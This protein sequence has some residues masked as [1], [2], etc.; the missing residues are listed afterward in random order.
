MNSPWQ[1]YLAK[2]EE[3][4]EDLILLLQELVHR[5][6][7]V[8]EKE[9][10]LFIMA[11]LEKRGI[12]SDL[13]NLDVDRL[14]THPAWVETGLSYKDRPNL[15]ATLKG[16]GQGK[17][18]SLL[19][20]IDVVPVE[21]IDQW[22]E[23]NP[24]SGKIIENKLFGRGS[25]DMKAG[26][27]IGLFLMATLK[28]SGLKIKGDLIFQS[29]IDEENG[30]NG[31]LAA[32]VRG[33]RADSSIFLEPSEEDYMGISGRGA[34]FFRITIPGQSGGIEYQYS[35]PNAIGKAMIIFQAV[36]RYADYLN[37][38]ANHPLYQYTDT[39]VPCAVCT[40]QAGNWPSTT[41]AYCAMEGS[42]ECLPGE[43][44]DVA[45]EQFKNY[46]LLSAKQDPWL[47]EHPPKIEWFGLRLE[48]AEIPIDSPIVECVRNASRLVLNK[49]VIPLGGG[50]S[51]LR[52][53]VLYADSP[54][55]NYG[56]KGGAI[57]ST[58]EYV[59]LNSVRN[60]TMV[61]GK[62]ILDWCEVAD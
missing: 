45:K 54:C 52:L 10:Q 22:V 4:F 62:V 46:L 16:T 30:G 59:D 38:T 41:P 26:V 56:P 23:A 50:G 53:P 44:I 1:T 14:K 7:H 42:L 21:E 11:W 9:C 31:T 49:D 6:S 20:H 55:I 29:L 60:V 25:L 51:D 15:A 36:E 57:H 8:S 61:V 28:E 39:K 5:P 48:S 58:N 37:S 27:A 12:E 2:I 34:Q 32:I 17:S 19:G 18:L 47:S 24:W 3:N 43:D 33:Y 40:I 35:T 13:W